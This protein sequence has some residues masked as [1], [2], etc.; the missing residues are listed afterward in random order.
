MK[1]TI[2]IT[3]TCVGCGECVD[4]CPADVLVMNDGMA[5]SLNQEQCIGCVVCEDTC[6]VNSISVQQK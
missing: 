4:M 6:S 1:Y 3:D 2:I 5:E